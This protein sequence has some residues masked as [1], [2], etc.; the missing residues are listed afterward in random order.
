M[1]GELTDT[2]TAD[3]VLTQAGLANTRITDHILQISDS[4]GNACT[5]ITGKDRALLFDAMTGREDLRSYVGKITDLPLTIVASHGHYDHTGGLWQFEDADL[6]MNSAELEI[7]EENCR[8]IPEVMRN[9][10]GTLPEKLLLGEYEVHFQDISEGKIFPLGGIKAEAVELPGHTLGSMGLLIREERILLVGD[11][12][13]PQMCLFFPES[14]PMETYLLTLSKVRDLPADRIL[15]GHFTR[16]FP[17]ESV[18]LFFKCAGIVGKK[19]GIAYRFLPLPRYHGT[20]YLYDVRS[21]LIG[22]TIC[23]IV[24]DGEGSCLP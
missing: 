5:L 22:E 17:M 15:G 3:P 19:R 20:F 13:S 21:K 23:I 2:R 14:L 12:V 24:P 18:D 16:C 7:Y 8:L 6:Y 1:Q 10:G 4:R 11:A 9:T